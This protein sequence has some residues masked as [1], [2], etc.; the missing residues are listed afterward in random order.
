MLDVMD[1]VGVEPTLGLHDAEDDVPNVNLGD[2]GMRGAKTV[3]F[4]VNSPY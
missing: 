2:F 1:K 3:G 4:S